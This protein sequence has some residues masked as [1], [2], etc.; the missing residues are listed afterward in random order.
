M[1]RDVRDSAMLL[2]AVANVDMRDPFSMTSAPPDY[3]GELE[4]GVKGLR[5]AWSPDLGRVSFEDDNVVALCHG[6]ARVFEK[7]GAI[8][9]EPYVRLE[10]P[11]DQLEQNKEY[12][13]EQMDA[14]FR[15]IQ[16]GYENVMVWAS[17]LPREDYAKLSVYFRNRDVHPNEV[18]YAMSISPEVR[19][20]KKTRLADLFSQIDLL[21]SPVIG[22]TAFRFDEPGITP[23]QYTAYTHVVNVAGY[24]AAS[25]PIGFHDGM[26]VGLHIIGRPNEEHL[27]LRAARAFERERPWADKKPDLSV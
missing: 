3:L 8:Y 4:K 10:D 5:M 21:M 7:L 6:A 18:D 16:P 11:H 19:Y 15:S 9:S 13:R 23:W 25:V 24:C 1:T 20:R 12:S 14:L 17:K 22:R 26:P 2:Q 27:V